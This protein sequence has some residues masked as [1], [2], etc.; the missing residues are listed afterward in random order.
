LLLLAEQGKNLYYIGDADPFGAEIY[1]TYVFGSVRFAIC[2]QKQ[3]NERL[4]M[5][6]I[7]PFMQDYP[8]LAKLNTIKMT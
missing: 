1:F 3:M 7:G 5:A 2:E 6:W 8:N 4:K